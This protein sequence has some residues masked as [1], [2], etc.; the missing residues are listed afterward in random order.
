MERFT[1]ENFLYL[2]YIEDD[3]ESYRKAGDIV[4][5]RKDWLIDEL[6]GRRFKTCFNDSDLIYEE[7]KDVDEN[8]VVFSRIYNSITV[9]KDVD[10]EVYLWSDDYLYLDDWL[11]S[12][13]DSYDIELIN[14]INKEV[15]PNAN[16]DKKLVKLIEGCPNINGRITMHFKEGEVLDFTNPSV[17][18]LFYNPNF[19]DVFAKTE[20]IM[21]EEKE[22]LFKEDFSNVIYE[23]E[24][25][26]Y[27]TTIKV[28]QHYFKIKEGIR[29]ISADDIAKLL[30]MK[31]FNS[32][33]YCVARDEEGYI[34]HISTLT[35]YDRSSNRLTEQGV[36]KIADRISS[37]E[38]MEIY[39]KQCAAIERA[40]ELENE[41][42]KKRMEEERKEL[43]DLYQEKKNNPEIFPG[44]NGDFIHIN[45]NIQ[46][47]KY[48]LEQIKEFYQN[49][50]K[51]D[52][53]V[54]K[55]ICF[56]G[57][58]VPYILNN[59]SDSREFGDID[60]FVPIEYMEKLRDEFAHQDTFEM[61]SDSKKYTEECMLTSRIA[62]ETT[63]IVKKEDSNS[64]YDAVS[65][66]YD[67]F[68]RLMSMGDD[69]EATRDYID[70]FGIVHNPYNVH[71]EDELPYYRKLQ[72]FGFKAKLFGINI[73]VFPIY[74]Y[75]QDLMA[76]SF[77]IKDEHSFLL[78]VKVLD[79]TKLENF[80]KEVNVYDTIFNVLPLEYTLVSKQSAVDEK[81]AFRYEKDKEDVGYILSHKDELGISNEKL[82]EILDNYPD[83]SISI[84]YAIG[85]GEVYT[86]SGEEYKEYVLRNRVVS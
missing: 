30:G 36:L 31:Y 40:R 25:G 53:E 21:G 44:V 68:S 63:E 28:E 70:E 43:D 12:H 45:K 83:Y 52:P 62:K 16:G 26:S 58:T 85:G 24:V 29:Y 41:A 78:G 81:Y 2:R 66:L 7:N 1:K 15:I 56:Y 74:E 67:T 13:L 27:A 18:A 84:A 73:S 47:E 79:N 3:P 86:M 9:S 82:E 22:S 60:M 54:V 14:H 71:K 6:R 64:L 38:A 23:A 59:A 61:I 65:S 50:K 11:F 46:K 72:D 49:L 80:V 34:T 57:G 17:I 76:K 33:E 35:K 55:H 77:N 8:E 5:Y 75:K 51:L 39:K 4:R 10:G 20:I 32:I 42:W 69:P 19:I 37:T 48:S